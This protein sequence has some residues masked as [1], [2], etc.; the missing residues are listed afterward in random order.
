[1]SVSYLGPTIT[2][3]IRFVGFQVEEFYKVI[4]REEE[5]F[6]LFVFWNVVTNLSLPVF[7]PPK[8]HNQYL[9][10]ECLSSSGKK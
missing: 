10:T 2:V 5:V 9:G 1:M 8:P 4:Y 7:A 6:S 3:N